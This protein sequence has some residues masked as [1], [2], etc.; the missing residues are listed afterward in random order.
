M[1][2]ITLAP[3]TFDAAVPMRG[4][5]DFA[6]AWEEA[7]RLGKLFFGA[8]HIGSPAQNPEAYSRS[9]SLAR[10]ER[11][12]TPLLVMHGGRD[13][14]APARQH[15]LLVAALKKYGKEF[16]ERVYGD[17]AHGFGPASQIDMYGRLVEFFDRYLKK[18]GASPQ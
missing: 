8:G 15:A 13:V 14:R 1:A 10:V 5:Y 6:E 2:A 9:S 3:D 17:E 7:D 18:R 11:I 16:E 12:K 4:I